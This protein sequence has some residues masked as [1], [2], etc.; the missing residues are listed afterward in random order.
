MH[1]AKHIARFRRRE[2]QAHFR[3]PMYVRSARSE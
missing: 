3:R 2:N 1:F